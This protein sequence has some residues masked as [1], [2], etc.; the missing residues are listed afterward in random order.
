MINSG[1]ILAGGLNSRMGG[2]P[3]GK[4]RLDGDHFVQRLERILSPKVNNVYYSIHREV[5]NCLPEDCNV[6]ADDFP[7]V[8]ASMN[9]VYSSLETLQAP[10]LIVPWDMPL[11]TD[12][13]LKKLLERSTNSP[14]HGTFYRTEQGI[15]PFPGVYRPNMLDSLKK[16]LSEGI[17]S[18]TELI[19]EL[20]VNE[21]RQFEPQDLSNSEWS[22]FWNINTPEDY[23]KLK[24][25]N[26]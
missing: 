3:K 14:K 6:I 23:Q 12:A 24:L 9:G 26:Q 13:L 8:R 11:V 10:T 20:D 22:V 7:D 17:F 4:L 16:R 18:L 1:V 25:Q 19:A 2:Y 21:I 15:E 5:P